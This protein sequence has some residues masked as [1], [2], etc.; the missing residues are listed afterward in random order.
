[1]REKVAGEREWWGVSKLRDGGEIGWGWVRWKG[2]S[3][4]L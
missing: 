1:M 3:V 4:F 2:G